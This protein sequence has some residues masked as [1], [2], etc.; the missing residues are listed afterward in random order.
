MKRNG[1]FLCE[2]CGAR[3]AT[4]DLVCAQCDRELA[5]YKAHFVDDPA[6]EWQRPSRRQLSALAL[7]YF[8]LVPLVRA[9]AGYWE[10]EVPGAR[11]ALLDHLVVTLFLLPILLALWGAFMLEK[12]WKSR[13]PVSATFLAIAAALAASVPVGTFLT[14]YARRFIEG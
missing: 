2:Q 1:P 6:P 13:F 14:I 8:V 5:T 12:R 4:P 11:K 3:L 9:I 7:A 10:N